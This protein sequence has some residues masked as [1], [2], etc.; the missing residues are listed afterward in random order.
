MPPDWRLIR[1]IN[2]AYKGIRQA[3]RLQGQ[4]VQWFRFNS[5]ATTSDPIY[6]TGPQR[7]W[8]N[9]I[10]VPAYIGE[11][12]RAKEN[13]DD[14][15]LYPVH[16]IHGIMSYREFFQST[17]PDPDYTGQNHLNDRIGFDGWL[18]AVVGFLPQGRVAD[19]FLTV[20]FDANQ[21]AQEEL[22]ED[23]QDPMFGPYVVAF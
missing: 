20:S 9:P 16:R 12:I 4:T 10:S 1:E 22:D 17:I 14:D 21:V 15:G 13:I 18:F 11:V 6:G 7:Q 2:S 3:Q 23:M 8:Y 19:Q 5:T